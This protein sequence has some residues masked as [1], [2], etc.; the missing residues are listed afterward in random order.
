ML[1]ETTSQTIQ[2]D[3]RLGSLDEVLEEVI[4]LEKADT[5]LV[6]N[7]SWDIPHDFDH[8]SRSIL[9][10]IQGFPELKSPLFRS[11]IGKT[12]FHIFDLMGRLSHDRLEEIPGSNYEQE[13]TVEDSIIKLRTTI[14]T[15][16]A[17]DKILE[18]HFAYGRLSKEKADRANA[19]HIAHH[20]CLIDY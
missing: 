15:F 16:K 5:I 4:K 1:I 17:F 14:E 11:L 8:C 13:L 19:M 6:S 18:P 7:D 2:R 3:L 10:M 12:A 9:Y 20:L